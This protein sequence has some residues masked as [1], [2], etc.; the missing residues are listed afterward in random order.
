MERSPFIPMVILLTGLLL[1][2]GYQATSAYRQNDQLSSDFD[3][4]APTVR[5]AQAV[6]DRFTAMVQDLVQLSSKDQYAAALVKTHFTK[7][8][9][10]GDATSPAASPGDASTP[11]PAAGDGTLP[12]SI[13][14]AGK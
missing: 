13:P 2:S 7:A 9:A 14:D 1:W 11:A 12:P 6:N 4:A 8:P 5:K 3:A 10:A